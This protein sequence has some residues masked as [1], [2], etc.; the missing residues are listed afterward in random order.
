M[1]TTGQRRLKQRLPDGKIVPRLP[2]MPTLQK[3]CWQQTQLTPLLHS[4]DDDPMCNLPWN[5][6][7][8]RLLLV[9]RYTC[10]TYLLPRPQL[11]PPPKLQNL[12]LTT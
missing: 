7:W 3:L 2:S 8:V 11:Q 4:D 12:L 6:E 1:T 10:K 9:L 5:L